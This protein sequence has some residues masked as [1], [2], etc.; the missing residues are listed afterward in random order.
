[1]RKRGCGSR[2]G[3]FSTT[4]ADRGDASRRIVSWRR[5]RHRSRGSRPRRPP[6]CSPT[7]PPSSTG[8]ASTG[9]VAPPSFRGP[10]QRGEICCGRTTAAAPALLE[11]LR[12]LAGRL[13]DLDRA[14]EGADRGRADADAGA[15]GAGGRGAGR[16]PVALAATSTGPGGGAGAPARRRAGTRPPVGRAVPAARP[17]AASS[18]SRRGS[19]E[20]DCRAGRGRGRRGRVRRAGRSRRRRGCAS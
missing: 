11:G 7:S 1:M 6:C 8:S 19:L 10:L 20:T 9:G 17:V 18:A 16:G 2:R 15:V 12:R 13:N 14:L 3:T 5:R 4:R